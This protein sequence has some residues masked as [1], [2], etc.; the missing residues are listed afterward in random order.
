MNDNSQ[1]YRKIAD[2]KLIFIG[3]SVGILFWILEAAIHASIFYHS[4]LID[5][6]LAPDLHEAWMRSV[7]VFLF[8]AF[9]IYAQFI[10]NTRKRAEERLQSS[11]ARLR[12]ILETVPSGFFMV[13]SDR[14]VT[15]WNKEAEEI[16]GLKAGEVIG[17]DCLEALRCEEC[18]KGCSLF[19]DE[20]NKPIYGLECVLHVDG[21][22]I[23]IS[24]NADILKDSKGHTIAGIESFVDITGRKQAEEELRKVNEEL[25][26]FAY[27]VSHDLKT[28]LAH[29]LG[30]SSVLLDSDQEKLGYKGRLCL[31]R[32][33]ASARRMDAFISDLLALSRIGRVVSTLKDAPSRAIVKNAIS[34]LQDRIEQN[35]IELV[36]ADN[37]PTI[38]CDEN[39]ICQLLENL[40]VNAIKFMGDTKNPKIVIGCED[41][42]EFHQ[43]HVMDNGI[44][45]DPTYHQEIFEKF[46]QVKEI[47]DDEGTGLGLAIVQR[48]VC[49]HGGR[50]WVES[51]KGKG[52]TFY[53]TL[54]KAP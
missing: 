44:G 41:R 43:F 11:E 4:G 29:I 50:V 39:R 9:G 5:E 15:Y 6:I 19:D 53:F 16:V 34:G 22:A 30:F 47:E 27:V 2:N 45:I 20:V 33:D 26:N 48:I 17:K 36:V 13:N 21:R 14:K 42:G 24:K 3:I 38:Y 23:T 51:E 7:I 31:E 10:V 25:K 46:N 37:L 49:N 28:P 1:M 32:I 52:A 54:P 40:L 8:I 35:G 18:E 12:L